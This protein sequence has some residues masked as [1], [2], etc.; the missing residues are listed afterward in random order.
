MIDKKI[1]AKII[2]HYGADIQSTVCM[3]ECAE[4][5][6]AVSKQKRGKSDKHHLAEEIA[7][8]TICLEMLMQIY[9]I[10]DSYI[11]NWIDIKMH[12]IEQRMNNGGK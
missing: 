11:N 6:Q 2:E 12:R 5:I 7:D 4:L 3:E 8:V 10:S 1:V 9:E